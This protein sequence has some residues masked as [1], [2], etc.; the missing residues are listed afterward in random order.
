M[1]LKRSN[2]KTRETNILHELIKP[3][4]TNI[5][6]GCFEKNIIKF[7]TNYVFNPPLLVNSYKKKVNA[8]CYVLILKSTPH[9]LYGQDIY[10]Y[11]Y[12]YICFGLA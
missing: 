1:V 9:N 3:T 12:V 5:E 6:Y 2:L 4:C 11:I 8:S 7:N 10:V